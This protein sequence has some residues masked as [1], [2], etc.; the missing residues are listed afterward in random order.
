MPVIEILAIDHRFEDLQPKG[1]IVNP[2]IVTSVA[3]LGPRYADYNALYSV[4]R[5]S[6]LVQP[7]DIIGFMGYRKYFLFSGGLQDYDYAHIVP[8]HAPDWYNCPR[9]VFD[10]YRRWWADWDGAQLLPLLATHDIIVTPPFPLPVDIIADFAASRSVDDAA[11]LYR[12]MP[13]ILSTGITPYLFITRWSVF[14]R[15][16]EELEPLRRE[17]DPLIT[18]AD[19]SNKEYKLRPMAY[20]MERVF[21]LWLEQSGL[22]TFTLP[23]LNCWELK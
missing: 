5:S 12:I 2:F 14:N 7:P 3:C 8:G 17:L 15:L 11:A 18:A 20:V 1:L 23:I 16:M 9:I 10:P 21:S 19:S 4:W 6:Y 22:A 13:D